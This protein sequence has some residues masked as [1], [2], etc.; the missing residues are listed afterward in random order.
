MDSHP[1]LQGTFLTQ[2]SNPG[3]LGCRQILYCLSHQGSRETE[4][5]IAQI[6]ESALNIILTIPRMVEKTQHV[7]WSHKY[8]KKT[9]IKFLEMKTTMSDVKI[10]KME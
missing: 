2:G 9:K 6:V 1:L 4:Q 3:L 5:E 8:T 7:K 10:Y